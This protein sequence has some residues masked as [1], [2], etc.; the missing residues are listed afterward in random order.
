MLQKGDLVYFDPPY[1]PV[2]SQLRPVTQKGLSDKD[3]P[4]ILGTF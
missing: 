1:Q 4:K 2:N 3:L